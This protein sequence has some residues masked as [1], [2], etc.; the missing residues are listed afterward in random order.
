MDSNDFVP[1]WESAKDKFDE[2]GRPMC[3]L[4][5]CNEP[6]F[7]KR[8]C[9]KHY[10]ARQRNALDPVTGLSVKSSSQKGYPASFK[11]YDKYVWLGPESVLF[12]ID[13]KI[14]WPLKSAINTWGSRVKEDIFNMKFKHYLG[15]IWDPRP[16]FASKDYFNSYA[17]LTNLMPED[18]GEGLH[19]NM[20]KLLDN[21]GQNDVE[22]LKDWLA[23]KIRYP[24]EC[25]GA[26]VI[27]GVQ[28]GGKGT[29]EAVMRA[30]FGE[31]CSSI[32]SLALAQDFNNWADRKFMIVADEINTKIQRDK[33]MVRKQL[34]KY[35][36]PNALLINRKYRDAFNISNHASWIIC[37]NDDHVVDIEEGDR[38]Y[39]V[40]KVAST[41]PDWLGREISNNADEYA[42][43][44]VNAFA[45]RDIKLFK[46]GQP[47]ENA[48]RKAMQ[49]QYRNLTL[50]S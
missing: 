25:T 3:V 13:A 37:S 15:E 33:E 48:A 39:S 49:N 17:P 30:L 24:W 6:H 10:Q 12:D 18:P 16:D 32:D 21:L 1:I 34:K 42:R 23:Y 44:L 20:A 29:L 4:P 31:H 46:K 7:C 8:L 14:K 50:D 45:F 35:T 27:H 41:I 2:S 5:A 11:G 19:E 26:I 28:R 40:L 36:A 43:N 9:N 47:L 38:R 22:W